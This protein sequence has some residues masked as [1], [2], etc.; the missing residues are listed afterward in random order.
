MTREAGGVQLSVARMSEVT[1]GVLAWQFWSA[2]RVPSTGPLRIV[3]EVV[4]ATVTRMFLLELLPDESV[5]V[6]TT[7]CRPRSR[8][9]PA[10][11]AWFRVMDS[12][13]VQ[14]SETVTRVNRFGNTAAQLALAERVTGPGQRSTGGWLSST[15][16][17]RLL[18]EEAPHGSVTLRVMT[19]V[20]RAKLAVNV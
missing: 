10:V 18:C 12:T 16:R 1:A 17:V 7:V 2:G 20:P 11:G 6:T 9:V 15:T 8:I 13:G 19:L 3:G 5:A 4:S 14:L